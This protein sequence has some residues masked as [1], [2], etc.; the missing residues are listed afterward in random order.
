MNLKCYSNLINFYFK[1]YKGNR[2][3][4]TQITKI[5]QDR[6][7]LPEISQFAMEVLIDND[8]KKQKVNDTIKQL[9]EIGFN[10]RMFPAVA[11]PKRRFFI[12]L[13]LE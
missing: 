9:V 6:K 2:A 7:W 1:R 5:V 13:E 4:T 10:V 11:N 8:I 12:T 3:V